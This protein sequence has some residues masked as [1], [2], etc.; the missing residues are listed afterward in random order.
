MSE[1]IL[2]ADG[3]PASREFIASHLRE[4][5]W[6]VIAVA[7]G[8]AA[9]AEIRERRPQLVVLD[10][11]LPETSALEVCRRVR[12]DPDTAT[13]PLLMV[14]ARASELDRVVAFEV[15][16]DDFVE[17]PCSG[18]ELALR[19]Q[20]VLRRSQPQRAQSTQRV[21]T[22]PLVVDEARH[23]VTVAGREVALTRLEFQLL[24]FLAANR[25]RVHS[26][27]ALLAR[28]WGLGPDI[29]TRTVDTYIK[30]LRAKLGDSGALIE[31]VRGVGYRLHDA[32]ARRL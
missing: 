5:G 25:E 28:V 23:R 11:A 15:G 21:T 10:L 8:T 31:T 13:L 6:L 1:R 29:E 3:D 30:R 14:S 19:V 2:V 24:T 12:R 17:K 4:A 32:T 20:A 7:D 26:R 27:E 16:V 18:R 22:G 9:L